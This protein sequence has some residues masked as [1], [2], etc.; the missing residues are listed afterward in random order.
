MLFNLVQI[1]NNSKTFWCLT[2]LFQTGEISRLLEEKEAVLS[3]VQR[4]KLAF[5][6]QADELKRQV[7][8][9]TKVCHI[10]AHNVQTKLIL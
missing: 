5:S 10:A 6:Q 3:Q 2:L 7:E 4:A 8:E 9:E 1:T